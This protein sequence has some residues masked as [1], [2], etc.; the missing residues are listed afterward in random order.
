[1]STLAR[2]PTYFTRIV[3][4]SIDLLNFVAVASLALVVVPPVVGTPVS[5]ST[6]DGG[7][8]FTKAVSYQSAYGSPLTLRTIVP[9]DQTDWPNPIRGIARHQ[10]WIFQ[11]TRILTAVADPP[12][13][14]LDWPNPTLRK[15]VPQSHEDHYSFLDIPR[16]ATEW[17]NPQLRTVSRQD[18]IGPSNN[19][20][21]AP[22]APTYA[23]GGVGE[24]SGPTFLKDQ[25][26]LGATRLGTPLS[27]LTSTAQAPFDQTDWPNPRGST[28]VQDWQLRT[29][30]QI[31]ATIVPAGALKDW[32]NPRGYSRNEQLGWTQPGNALAAS[33]GNP[34]PRDFD[35]PNPQPNRY[36]VYYGTW[37]D[38]F[39]LPLTTVR[40]PYLQTDWPVPRGYQHPVSLRTWTD[41]FKLPLTTVRAPY[42][43]ADWPVPKAA[44][45]VLQDF[46]PPVPLPIQT[47][48]AV[49]YTLS[50]SAEVSGPEFRIDQNYVRATRLGSPITVLTTVS[51]TPFAQKDW[52]NPRGIRNPQ[53]WQLR[54]P[55][56]LLATIK[57]PYTQFDWPVP[58]G[59]KPGVQ[60][61]VT[62][63]SLA[64]ATVDLSPA[65]EISWPSF[66]QD[67][68]SV[69][70]TALG[71]PRLLFV[72]VVSPATIVF[73]W[74]NPRGPIFPISLRTWSDSFKLPLTTV[75]PPSIQRD[76]PVPK[77]HGPRQS[78]TQ[79]ALTIA[80][81]VP[82][83]P[84]PSQKNWPNPLPYPPLK[85]TYEFPASQNFWPPTPPI[86]P[87]IPTV[88]PRA[89][90]IKAS[91]SGP[92]GISQVSGPRAKTLVRGPKGR[93][94]A[95]DP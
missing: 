24:I 52:P 47:A 32:P 18:W 10:D 94:D 21:L 26:Y 59:A 69:W 23:L 66:T 80:T 27:V 84:P 87:P 46:C 90:F 11:G 45:G 70:A 9:F 14:Q 1:M 33:L 40:A 77:G 57:P 12:R 41:S 75:R 64:L 37:T 6:I 35:W 72:P 7:G 60:D 55:P 28:R 68:T 4:K 50:S 20:L 81:F 3:P 15:L 48:V 71:S 56:Q 49:V 82:P 39:K 13:K 16:N 34:P 38:S 53:D 83:T 79:V 5:A 51:G 44:K 85:I 95:S 19:L 92:G 74:P 76:W 30:Q 58:R 29:P 91:V 42:L 61:W 17:V 65:T 78:F 2:S 63:A 36:S 8:T 43:Q 73:D 31:L 88:L 25:T 62:G 89:K 93:T 67:R 54:T 22:V 86:P